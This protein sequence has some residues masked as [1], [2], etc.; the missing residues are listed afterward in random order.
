MGIRNL[1]KFLRTNCSASIYFKS[2]SE[3]SGQKI[4]VDISIY[5]YK[6]KADNNLVENIYLMLSIFMHYNIIPVF[7]FD[8]KPPKE[9]HKLLTKR[10]N[11]KQIAKNEY[12]RLKKTLQTEN[13]LEEFDKHEL[14]LNMDLLKRQFITI[15]KDDI[16]T[17]KSLIRAHGASYI[18]AHGE[19][20]E[21][22]AML[23][24]RN[25]VF[26]CLSEDMDLFVYGCPRV[27]RYLS[28][29]NH[30]AVLYN[31]PEILSQLGLSQNELMEICILSG[32]DYNA[33]TDVKNHDLY[34]T[35]K[36][37][38]RFREQ[39]ICNEFY[40]WLYNNTDY[41]NNMEELIHIKS[42]FELKND[43]FEFIDNININ[44]G[45]TIKNDLIKILKNDGF[46]FP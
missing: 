26:A 38:K 32:T 28:L 30:T 45:N 41:I 21:L 6:Y 39:T 12:N 3:L 36:Q 16:N 17:V 31:L 5:M 46:L 13:E 24:K 4:A 33:F 25:K 7:I 10:K 11:D 37:F 15:N 29:L 9:K 40:N 43:D 27:I 22:C 14:I 20:D 23:V 35:L 34:T 1:N 8:G 44:N 2:L 42:M 19:A 18:D